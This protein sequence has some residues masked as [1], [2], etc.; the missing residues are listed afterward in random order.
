[1]SKSALITGIPGQNGPS[2][3]VL[4]GMRFTAQFTDA[5][6]HSVGLDRRDNVEIEAYLH[7]V[8]VNYCFGDASKPTREL[9][10]KLEILWT[11]LDQ[12]N[13]EIVVKHFAD[14]CSGCLAR[15]PE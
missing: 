13:T 11:A 4:R 15:D 3:C 2:C 7:P 1:M 14:V 5:A 12:I 8:A 9:G 10:W 6:F